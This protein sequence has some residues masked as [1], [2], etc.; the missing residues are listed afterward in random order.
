MKTSYREISNTD[1]EVSVISDED[2]AIVIG[3][4][5]CSQYGKWSSI[6][7]YFPVP[8]FLSDTV[9]S[10]DSMVECGRNLVAAWTKFGAQQRFDEKLKQIKLTEQKAA[11]ARKQKEI[12][13]Q[14]FDDLWDLSTYDPFEGEP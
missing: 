6:H 13:D 4:I 5:S 10:K 2:G 12:D 9:K 8:S 1:V 7:E 11:E 14:Y 3:I